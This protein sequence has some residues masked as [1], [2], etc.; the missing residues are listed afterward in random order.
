[1]EFLH[2]Q[3]FFQVKPFVTILVLILEKKEEKKL[4]VDATLFLK[5]LIQNTQKGNF[6]QIHCVTHLFSGW[7]QHIPFFLKQEPSLLPPQN[8]GA[9]ITQ[10]RLRDFGLIHLAC[11]S[12]K[13]P[14][15]T[16]WMHKRKKTWG[17]LWLES[18][19]QLCC[20][21]ELC[22]DHFPQRLSHKERCGSRLC[23]IVFYSAWKMKIT[24]SSQDPFI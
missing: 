2:F 5:C 23:Q 8:I 24:L 4:K 19:F 11:M 1:M 20:F 21:Y 12:V 15:K 14:V 6:I 10:L 16:L 7:N 3:T 22:C 18:K 13:Y 9:N 17:K